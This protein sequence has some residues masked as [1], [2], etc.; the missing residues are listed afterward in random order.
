MF[1]EISKLLL[2]ADNVKIMPK[3]MIVDINFFIF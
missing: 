1:L 3:R 2:W